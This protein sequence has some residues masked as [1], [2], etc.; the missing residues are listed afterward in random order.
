MR[1]L[2]ALLVGLAIAPQTAPPS[3]RLQAFSSTAGPYGTFWRLTIEPDGA[4]EVKSSDMLHDRKPDTRRWVLTD[5]Q[6]AS[7]AAAI[8]SAD[9]FTLPA[10]LGPEEVPLHGPENTLRV[11]MNGREHTV[12]FYGPGSG[13]GPSIERFRTVWRVVA[14]VS[15]VKPP[16]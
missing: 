10:S 16:L 6:R 5:A 14:G 4:A 15:P 7:L 1:I 11:R 13:V 8:A 9:F 3:V 12:H 2:L